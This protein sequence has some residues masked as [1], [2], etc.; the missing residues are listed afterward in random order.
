MSA[1]IKS[2]FIDILI[3]YSR[4]FRKTI[5]TFVPNSCYI[6]IM[7]TNSL[8][9]MFLFYGLSFFILGFV[10]LFLR[11]GK[12]T[13]DTLLR[14]LLY[15]GIFGI[16]HGLAEWAVLYQHIAQISGGRFL[17]S[18]FIII[19]NGIS[20]LYLAIFSLRLNEI[21]L[22]PILIGWAI[23]LTTGLI[24][25]SPFPNDSI[26]RWLLGCP[27]SFL[28]GVGLIIE[29]RRFRK[30]GKFK[31][32][33]P[34]IFL[35]ISFCLYGIA[36][37]IVFPQSNADGEPFRPEVI[38]L[39]LT[40]FS[41][42]SITLI[43]IRIRSSEQKLLWGLKKDEVIFRERM[44]LGR[45]LH[46]RVLQKLFAAGLTMDRCL[47]TK[48]K[49]TED[50]I[51]A[52]RMISESSKSIRQFLHSIQDHPVKIRDFLS[53]VE[54]ECS[55]MSRNMKVE[56]K[57]DMKG[58]YPV[59]LESDNYWLKNSDDVLAI[60]EEAINNAIRHSGEKV[61]YVFLE[62]KENLIMEISDR[63]CGYDTEK[64]GMG[65]GL[66]FMSNRARSIGAELT[67]TSSSDGTKIQLIQSLD[68][69]TQQEGT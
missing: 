2:T 62:Y 23:I 59:L 1:L 50:V 37:G 61:I 20:F 31:I 28:S 10:S 6:M 43:G 30:S 27:A 33:N 3:F 47:E 25:D 57:L 16:L 24:I 52:R 66:K 45:D 11:S 68:F 64:A 29:G 38:R 9:I 69:K 41:S 4:I 14:N 48:E 18:H 67:T 51:M 15:L 26:V 7:S 13:S 49:S 35:A 44:R 42:L 63:G 12:Y 32:G 53:L 36:V 19:L 55:R 46:D 34:L 22:F 39:F 5:R 8:Y 56:I 54:D 40:I 17:P 58:F 60:L 65:N 21:K